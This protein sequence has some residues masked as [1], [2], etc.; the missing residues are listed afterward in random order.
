MKLS[1]MLSFA[2]LQAAA[3]AQDKLIAPGSPYNISYVSGSLTV[4]GKIY[5]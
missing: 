5:C 4:N 3:Q 1:L 2:L